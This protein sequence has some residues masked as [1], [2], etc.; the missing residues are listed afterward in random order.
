MRSLN[1]EKSGGRLADGHT[2]KDPRED[3]NDDQINQDRNAAHERGDKN[4]GIEAIGHFR[5]PGPVRRTGRDLHGTFVPAATAGHD[6]D[7]DSKAEKK[8]GEE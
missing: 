4:K 1:R 5:E 8:K 6:P 7:G 3:Q 2:S